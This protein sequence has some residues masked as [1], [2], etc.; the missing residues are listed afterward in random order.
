MSVMDGESAMVFVVESKVGERE[1]TKAERRMVEIWT[2]KGVVAQLIF[3]LL[4][5]VNS[6]LKAVELVCSLLLPVTLEALF[7]F[8]LD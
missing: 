5:L 6:R 1:G 4:A 8:S 2:W 7:T 3:C